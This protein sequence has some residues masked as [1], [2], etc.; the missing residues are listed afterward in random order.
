[1]ASPSIVI[2]HLRACAWF[3]ADPL[4]PRLSPGTEGWLDLA[5]GPP[6]VAFVEPMVR[7]RLSR[8]ARGFFHCAQ[9]LS[10]AGDVRVVFAS[11]HGEAHHSWAILQ[12][13]AAEQEV[14]PNLFSMSVHNAIPGLWSI[15]KGNRAPVTA[16]AAGAETFGWGLVEAAGALAAEPGTPVLYLY[17]DDQLPPLWAAQCP[18][19]GLHAVAQL[20]GGEG[21]R[22]T[23]QREAPPAGSEG[24]ESHQFLGAWREG[25][26]HWGTWRG[27]FEEA[28]L[29]ATSC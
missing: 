15:L 21:R 24:H 3:E 20:L 12:E 22:L 29:Q 2:P 23:F 6:E 14:S 28:P 13:L 26:G 4:D 7:R 11:R 16:L 5:W 19:P 17:A 27:R 1:M 9:R 8:L 25:E 18:Q 10:P